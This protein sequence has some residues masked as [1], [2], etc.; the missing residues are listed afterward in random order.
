MGKFL[1]GS[2]QTG[3]KI[4]ENLLDF[5][6]EFEGIK[7]SIY[8]FNWKFREQ[9]GY[10]TIKLTDNGYID[11]YSTLGCENNKGEFTRPLGVYNDKS[12]YKVFSFM[13]KSIGVEHSI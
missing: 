2:A 7:E 3:E 12:L 10:A 13:L 8:N 5:H 1:K 4:M 11:K 6:Y 9:S